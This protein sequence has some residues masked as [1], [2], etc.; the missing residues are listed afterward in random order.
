MEQEQ[1]IQNIIN[2]IISYLN[3]LKGF[4]KVKEDFIINIENK[5][6]DSKNHSFIFREFNVETYVINKEFFDEFRNAI[7]FEQLIDILDPINE[8]NKK[9]ALE[10]LKTYLNKN[11]FTLNENKLK[12]FSELKEMKEV[13]KNINN[14][15]FINEDI[16]CNGMGINKLTLEGKKFKVSKNKD[17]LCLISLSRNF[18]LIIKSDKKNIDENKEDEIKKFKNLYYV[19]DITKKIFILLYINELKLK[20]K[21]KRHITHN[22]KFKKYYLINKNWLERYKKFFLYDFIIKK[23][24]E[25]FNREYNDKENNNDKK[26]R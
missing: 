15:S 5:D 6:N 23:F 7:N 2:S 13:V 25:E 24:K 18:S 17:N 26:K 4:K 20:Y 10:E 12:I 16:L 8:E 1:K 9:K 11:P 22:Y 3:F 21:V 14:I 19:E